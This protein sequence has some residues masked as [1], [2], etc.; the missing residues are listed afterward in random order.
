LLDEI[1]F[2]F[3]Y[4]TF[5]ISEP[6]GDPC[7]GFLCN[8]ANEKEESLTS[9]PKTLQPVEKLSAELMKSR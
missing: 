7:Y 9:V 1:C 3:Q 5:D 2:V 8:L 4:I 6:A